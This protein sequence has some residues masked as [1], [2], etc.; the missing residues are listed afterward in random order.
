MGQISLT[1]LDSTNVS[2]PPDAEKK[3]QIRPQEFVDQLRPLINS[4]KS[5]VNTGAQQL[6]VLQTFQTT[7][8]KGSNLMIWKVISK[9]FW[10]TL[11]KQQ[12]H[13][14]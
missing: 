1:A 4:F 10:R 14:Q 2:P 12:F 13:I 6:A 3:D 5:L 8:I 11:I 9:T 7:F